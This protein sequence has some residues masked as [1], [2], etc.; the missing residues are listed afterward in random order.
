MV[1]GFNCGILRTGSALV[2]FSFNYFWLFF[3][4]SLFF[5][6]NSSSDLFCFDGTRWRYCDGSTALSS[7]CV[8]R[9]SVYRCLMSA[10]SCCCLNVIAPNGSGP[11]MCLFLI[12]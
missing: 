4:I 11:W 7:S 1:E 9:L 12:S 2:W 3:I 6:M 5:L 10:R 8:P